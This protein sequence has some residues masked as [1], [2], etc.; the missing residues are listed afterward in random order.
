MAAMTREKPKKP[1][2]RSLARLLAVQGIYLLKMNPDATPE[3][4]VD[5]FRRMSLGAGEGMPQITEVDEPLLRDILKGV[6]ERRAEIKENLQ[7]VLT[8]GWTYQRLEN[9]LAA[10]LEGGVYEL[11]ARPDIPRPVIINEYVN[12]AHAFYEGDEPGFVN[13]ILDELAKTIRA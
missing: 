10:I 6:F 11:L 1:S 2:A 9:I 7:K 12:V 3:G 13:G 5:D 8:K 4:I